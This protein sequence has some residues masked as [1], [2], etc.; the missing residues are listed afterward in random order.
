MCKRSYEPTIDPVWRGNTLRQAEPWIRKCLKYDPVCRQRG[1]GKGLPTRVIDVGPS[2]GSQD[3][4]IYIPEQ[5]I[6]AE[7]DKGNENGPSED[8][9][10]WQAFIKGKG[11]SYGK[12]RYV[13]LSYCWGKTQN[14]VTTLENIESLKSC[15]P[16]SDIP[17]TV[18]GAISITRGLGIRYLW[19]DA[20]CI[21]QDSPEDWD[22]ESVKMANV[23]GGA[24]LTLSAAHGADVNEGLPRRVATEKHRFPLQNDH[25]YSRAWALQERMLSTRVLIF[26]SDQ[27]Y[28]ECHHTQE[29][30]DGKKLPATMS[31]RLPQNPSRKDWNRIVQDY[32]S[33]CLT[34]EMDK[35][36]AVSGLAEVYRQATNH[37]YMAGLWR[38]T[39]LK[40]LLWKQHWLLYGNKVEPGIPSRWRAPSWSWA[41]IDGNVRMIEF[42]KDE[43]VENSTIVGTH[44]DVALNLSGSPRGHWICLSGPLLEGDI[45]ADKIFFIGGGYCALWIDIPE[46]T[47][48]GP[49]RSDVGPSTDWQYEAPEQ[50]SVWCLLIVTTKY[51][52]YYEGHGLVL[53]KSDVVGESVFRRVGYFITVG[54]KGESPSWKTQFEECKAS[55][56]FLI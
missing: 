48:G 44:M 25:L 10:W 19:V 40:N 32:T 11:V 17:Q 33:R 8:W 27:I 5:P 28:W 4:F 29:G 1:H 36:P 16:W 18:R 6:L 42:P 45:K 37:T 51:N 46:D 41:S 23:Y 12:T 22:K 43:G 53:A 26:G 14:L 52:G 30:E 35:L 50:K 31:Y 15:I 54:T 47:S 38:E 7:E 49:Q 13:S 24:F 3:P 9:I 39:L 21:I 56:I 34:N 2:D 55:T 20:L